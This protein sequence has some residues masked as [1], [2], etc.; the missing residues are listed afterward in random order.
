MS[1]EIPKTIHYCWF[2]RNPLNK[3]AKKCIKSWRK[4]CPDYAIVEWNEDNYD[5]ASKPRYVREAYAA[6]KWAFVSDYARFDILYHYGGLYFDTDVEIIR[7]L[8]DLVSKGPFMGCEA[9]A[10]MELAA[11]SI[12]VAPGLGIAANPGLGIYKQMLDSYANEEFVREDGTYNY[13]TVVERA[14]RILQLNGLTDVPGIQ[15]VA[16]ITVYPS[17]YFCPL[18]YRTRIL[19]KTQNTRT[20]HWYDGSWYSKERRKAQNRSIRL[21]RIQRMKDKIRLIIGNRAYERFK[22]LFTKR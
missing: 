10:Q 14:T 18:D 15:S 17:E 6:Q 4:Y 19:T 21:R 3:M 1:N 22:Q 11:N 9:D 12:S 2:G 8:H 7:P 16:G 13:S 5:I 20:I